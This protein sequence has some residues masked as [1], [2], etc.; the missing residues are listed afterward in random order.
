MKSIHILLVEDNE[1]DIL[2]TSEVLEEA[3]IH[4]K[5][6]ILKDGKEAMDFLNKKGK[7]QGADLPGLL[8]LDINLPKKDGQEG[9]QNIKGNENL[10]HIPVIMLSTSSVNKDYHG[11]LYEPFHHP[12]FKLRPL[13]FL[14]I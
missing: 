8:L 13:F 12:N 2:L 9:L 14:K 10:K 11:I 6:S 3:Q 7:Y 5:L 4:A 1:G